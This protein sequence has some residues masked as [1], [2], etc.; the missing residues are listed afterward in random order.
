[1]QAHFQNEFSEDIV[2]T[3]SDHIEVSVMKGSKKDLNQDPVTMLLEFK[4]EL[5]MLT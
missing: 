3:K 1:M 4:T 2:Q 5:P